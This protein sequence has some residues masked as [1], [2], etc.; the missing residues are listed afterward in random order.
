VSTY[1]FDFYP[2]GKITFAEDGAYLTPATAYI[3]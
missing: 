2:L 1:A 3:G